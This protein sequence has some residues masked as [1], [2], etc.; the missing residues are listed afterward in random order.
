MSGC[1][2]CSMRPAGDRASKSSSQERLAHVSPFSPFQQ[3]LELAAPQDLQV[4][5]QPLDLCTGRRVG[6]HIGGQRCPP[7][8]V[9]CRCSPFSLQNKPAHKE[10]GEAGMCQACCNTRDPESK[11]RVPAAQASRRRS[12]RGGAT[13]P[14]YFLCCLPHVHVSSLELSLTLTCCAAPVARRACL[15]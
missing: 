5:A 14:I 9:L 2:L 1:V 11:T 12:T 8:D 3:C 4:L 7:L 10:T 13:P 15:R 6:L